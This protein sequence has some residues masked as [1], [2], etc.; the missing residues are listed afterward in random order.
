[1]PQTQDSSDVYY[2]VSHSF[3]IE[4]IVF[5]SLGGL[6]N[7]SKCPFSCQMYFEN[8]DGTRDGGVVQ[9]HRLLLQNLLYE[10]PGTYNSIHLIFGQNWVMLL[11]HIIYIYIYIYDNDLNTSRW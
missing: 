10:H 1:M 7:E 3:K 4:E 9:F 11:I 8:M 5:V 6:H 2:K